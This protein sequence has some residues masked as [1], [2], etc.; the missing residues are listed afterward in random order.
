MTDSGS[1][2]ALTLTGLTLS[3]AELSSGGAENDLRNILHRALQGGFAKTGQNPG[4]GE[5]S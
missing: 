2:L 3:M 4:K 5:G 1:T